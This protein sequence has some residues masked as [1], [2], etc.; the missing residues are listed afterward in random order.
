MNDGSLYMVT[1]WVKASGGCSAPAGKDAVAAMANVGRMK[2]RVDGPLT[3]GA[4]VQAQ[5][6]ISH[7]NSSGLAMDQVTHLYQPPYFVR[8]IMVTYGG[9]PVMDADVDFSISENPNFRFSFVPDGEGA[10]QV[11][12]LD[13]KDL[14][15]S[16]RLALKPR[17]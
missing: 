7:P 4:P 9:R 5:L 16:E 3:I 10:L 17:S 2:M 11:D 1:R 15:F 13:S 12:V 6:M 8:R 14:S